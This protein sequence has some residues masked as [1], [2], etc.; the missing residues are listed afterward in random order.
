MRG[1]NHSHN[2]EDAQFLAEEAWEA[3]EKL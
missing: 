3:L 1:K 2:V